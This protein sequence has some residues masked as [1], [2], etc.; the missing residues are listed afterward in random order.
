MRIAFLCKRH[1]TGKDVI[2]DQYG[3]LYEIPNQLACTG[4]DVRAW[5]LDYYGSSDSED[6]LQANDEAQVVWSSY[7][8]G[9]LRAIRL[10]TY[11][12][13]LH[14]Q[15]TKF[16]PDI[17]IGAS[18]IPHVSLAAWLGRQLSVPYVVDLYDNFES[19]GQAGIPGFKKLL[20]RAV[21][22][23]DLVITVGQ[24]LQEK[25]WMDYAPASAVLVMPNGINPHTFYPGNRIQARQTL[26]LPVH[27]K[28][29]GTAG[30]LSRM[31]GL[32]TVYAAWQHL[33]QTQPDLHLVLAGPVEKNFPP[34]GGP[35]VHYLGEL[36]AKKVADLFCALDVGIIPLKDS[37]F[38]RYCFP[39]KAYEMLSCHL[40]VVAANI[41][42]MASLFAP[43]PQAL[44]SPDNPQELIA[45]VLQQLKKPIFFALPVQS[46]EN[47][48]LKLSQEL[49]L[50]I[51]SRP[52]R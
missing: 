7:A 13:W 10:A 49:E 44:F 52:M 12:A 35:R 28:L 36:S 50:L 51:S 31:K 21:R 25:V 19:F 6:L 29:I 22:H 14:K 20:A 30:G 33:E 11:P 16:K 43:W 15:L 18:D 2:L 23:A 3:R 27:A 37:S 38:G 8:A 24:A 45:S 34:P 46:W 9:G 17:V 48:G 1:Y 41:G 4:H 40:P 39:Q 5:C 26:G 32:E 42:E 47:L